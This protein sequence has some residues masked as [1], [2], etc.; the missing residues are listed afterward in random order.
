MFSGEGA[1]GCPVGGSTAVAVVHCVQGGMRTSAG[2]LA[3]LCAQN[4]SFSKLAEVCWGQPTCCACMVETVTLK[5]SSLHQILT[6]Y[7]G[8]VLPILLCAVYI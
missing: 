6:M 3:M 5:A 1:V 4:W 2:A 8:S 7:P